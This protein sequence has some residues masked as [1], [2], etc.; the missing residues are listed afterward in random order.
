MLFFSSQVFASNTINVM[1]FNLRYA[2]ASDGSNSWENANQNPERRELVIRVITNHAP[3]VIGFQEGEDVQLTYLSDHLPAYAIESQKPSG[4]GGNENAAFA[5]NT[6]RLELLDR[7]TFSLGTQPGGGYWNNTPGTNFYPYRYFPNMGLGFPRLA[8]WGHFNWIETDQEFLFYSTHYDFNNEPQVKSAWLMTDDA[9]ARNNLMPSSPLAM[10][11]GDF[12]STQ[13]DHDWEFFTGSYTTNGLTGDFTDSWYQAHNS[14]T[15]SG[16]FHGFQGGT[17]SGN[18]RIDWILHRGG[19][20]ASNVVIVTDHTLSSNTVSPPWAKAG[21][22]APWIAYLADENDS[23]YCGWFN[24]TGTQI[25]N[26][27]SARQ[28]TYFENGG[29]L[30]GVLD[31]AQ[32]LGAGFTNVFYLAAAPYSTTNGGALYSGA[33]VPEGNGDGD[34]LG[35]NEYIRID[36]GDDDLDGINN[37]AD[38]DRDGDNLPDAWEELYNLNPDSDTGT[39][40]ASGDP[41][42]DQ[43][44]NLH[45][46]YACTSPTS[47]VST[48]KLIAP[49]WNGTQLTAAWP[50]LHGKEYK[51]WQSTSTTL[52]NNMPWSCFYTSNISTNFP[53]TTNTIN[54]SPGNTFLRMQMLP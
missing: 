10:V 33:Q 15:D 34:I 50:T 39:D 36:P 28:A 4:G 3:D 25:T 21:Q 32:L 7:G 23:D 1:T 38:P 19:F 45:E 27:F 12:N 46:F 37:Y 54:T 47:N 35:T 20:V 52:S 13:N 42:A 24:A 44:S 31:L 43:A 18:D 17:I 16:T 14:W 6:N 29:H 41:D 11:V 26:V 30:E 53:I 48:F 51:A 22:V 2:S 49:E 8:I 5:Y 40:G 9:F